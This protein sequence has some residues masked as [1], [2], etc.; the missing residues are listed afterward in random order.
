M[1][2]PH[3]GRL[4]D[5]LVPEEDRP[6]IREES[7]EL[8]N[9]PVSLEARKDYECMAYG[10]FSPLKGPLSRNDYQSVLGKGR[11]RN[12]MPWT[13]PIILDVS[14][15][16]AL[17]IEEGDDVA[18]SDS[19]E[20]FAVLHVE[21]KYGLDKK[22]H[23]ESVYK[24]LDPEHP[25][26]AKTNGMGAVL[27]GG[28]IDLFDE[29]PGKVPRYRLKPKETRFLFNEM[30]WRTVAGF[31]T[32]NAP[33]VGH[34][35]VQKTALAFVDGLFINPLI[36]RKKP[37]DFTDEVIV[38]SY[39]ALIRDYY[40][41]NSVVLVTLEMEMRYAGPREAIFHA[42]IRKNFGCTHFVVGRD[43]AGVG[44]YYGP[45]EAQDIFSKYPDLG[46]APIFFRSFFYC[47]K[48]G[49]VENDKVCPHGPED[50]VNF[51]G[52]KMRQLL[53]R[54]ERPSKEMMRP[55]VVDAILGHPE[56]FVS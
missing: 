12:D 20:P 24:T 38:E 14:E 52:T 19:G 36:G 51:S 46:I 13:F 21:D 6:R 17:E 25:G 39:E 10:M 34:E 35:Y 33:H 44:S 5:R 47:K 49:G 45:F 2:P 16:L 32:R 26:V 22:I 50:H 18:L 40:L 8:V 11:L 31:Q 48:C 54:G 43:H 41:R 15:E 56:P 29:T 53:M 28:D 3:G 9:I 4:I 42:I 30:G 27:L 23:A 1:L 37:G 7:S 55:E